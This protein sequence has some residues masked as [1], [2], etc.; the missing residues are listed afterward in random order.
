MNHQT[1]KIAS[2]SITF[3]DLLVYIYVTVDDWYQAYWRDQH[4]DERGAK[5]AMHASEVLTLMIAHDYLPYPGEGQFLAHIRANYLALFPN[6]FDRS[7]YNRRART[8]RYGLE[9]FRQ[10]L[11]KDMNAELEREVLLDTKP[12][13][14]VGYKRNKIRSDF[15]HSADYGVC[16]SRKL[17]YFGY[18]LVL[19]STK[20]G[21]PLVYDLVPANTDERAAAETVLCQVTGL[22]I[23]GDKGFI[24]DDW[25]RWQ[26]ES[27]H[28]RIV[29]PKRKN[30]H[31][32]NPI[33]LDRWLCSTRERIEGVFHEIQNTGRHLEHLR[34][35][36]VSGLVKRVCEKITSHLMRLW[37]KSR[38]CIDIQT[39]T[40]VVSN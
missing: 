37:L 36:K 4:R 13:P 5:G 15:D 27:T 8:L 3:A 6:L 22:T 19:L 38:F 1:Q 30:Q 33:E 23:L 12:V 35:K 40:I 9:C 11:L 17:C 10:W 25:Q 24:G 29:T 16:V 26:V 31:V 18:K 32:Q 2:E 39:F 28:N 34:A 7:Q 20:S 14:V 21:I